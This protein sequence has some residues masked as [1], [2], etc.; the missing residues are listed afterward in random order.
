MTL[1]I[2]ELPLDWF[3]RPQYRPRV[4]RAPGE[5]WFLLTPEFAPSSRVRPGPPREPPAGRKAV[6]LAFEETYEAWD[7][8]R[9]T[10]TRRSLDVLEREGTGLVITGQQPGFLGGPLHTVYKAI[11]AI[12]VARHYQAETGRACVP[13]FW[14][15][16][17]DHDFEEVR[18]ALLPG[19]DGN[20]VTFRFPGKSD[21]RPLSEYKVDADAAEVLETAASHLA[22]RRHSEKIRALLQLYRGRNLASGFAALLADLLGHTGMLF[23]DPVNVRPMAS[24]LI[25]RVIEEPE[26]ILARVEEGRM[27]VQ[28]HGMKPLVKGRLPLFLLRQGRR[29]HLSPA[30]GGLEVDG[31]GPIIAQKDLIETLEKDPRAFSAGALLR[32]VLQEACLPCVI[33]VGGP[34]EVGYFAQIGPLAAHFGLERPAIALRFNGTLVEGKMARTANGMSLATM[35]A[36]RRAEDLLLPREEPAALQAAR[37]LAERVER[38]LTTAAGDVAPPQ[39]AERLKRKAKDV[40]NSILHLTDRIATAHLHSRTQEVEEVRK[41]WNFTLP[42]DVLQ[43][44]RWNALHFISKHGTAW[45]DELIE[46]ITDD[47]LRVVHRWVMFGDG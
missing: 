39:Q 1:K 31:G 42:G 12:A 14:V 5:A 18:E 26:R 41:L 4:T 2:R 32:P 34:A 13:V 21:R 23:L 47:P 25:R 11:A 44:R 7:L 17:D 10:A 37:A 22:T 3:D 46:A 6:R 15:A 43:E 30:R 19:P 40:S 36:A 9:C 8:P 33:T 28:A 45:I 35:A 27:E 16:G 20:D 24:A 29:D 38:E